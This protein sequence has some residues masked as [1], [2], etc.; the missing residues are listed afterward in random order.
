MKKHPTPLA[1]KSAIYKQLIV[2]ATKNGM[3]S[4]DVIN[5]MNSIEEGFKQAH[6]EH[7][8]LRKA[9]YND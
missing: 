5:V 4:N 1:I 3:N 6:D 9:M 7:D 8:A 2:A